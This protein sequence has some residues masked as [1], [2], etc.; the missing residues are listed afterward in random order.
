VADYILTTQSEDRTGIVAALTKSLAGHEGFITEL[1]QFGTPSSE[2]FYSRISFRMEEDRLKVFKTDIESISR[3]LNLQT[4]IF[5]ADHKM[6]TLILVSKFDH[7][8]NDL[9][10]RWRKGSLPIQ[11][12]GVVSNHPDTQ[13]LVEKT[14]LPFYH[15]H[16]QTVFAR[17]I[18][19]KSSIYT[20]PSYQASRERA[21]IIELMKEGS[22]LSARQHIM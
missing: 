15:I 1:A 18:R 9:L 17:T 21:P 11:I 6:P 14:G 3:S 4:Q 13:S 7:C 20:T 22:N 10:Y 12:C 2:R 5:L 16:Y 19:V 8:L